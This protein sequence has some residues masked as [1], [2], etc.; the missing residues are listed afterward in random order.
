MRIT[1]DDL[2]RM[3][4]IERIIPEF[5]VIS[6]DNINRVTLYM[7]RKIA[8]FLIQTLSMTG[9]ELIEQRYERFRKF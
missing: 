1:A 4:V 3:G 5:P 2:K 8:G 9:Q 6:E 7:K